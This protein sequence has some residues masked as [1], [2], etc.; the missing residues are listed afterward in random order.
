MIEDRSGQN[1]VTSAV[2]WI[3]ASLTGELASAIAIIAVAS[4]GLML[5]S[6]RLDMRRAVHVI[7]GCFILFGASTIATGIMQMLN[8]AAVA[9]AQP[10]PPPVLAPPA[11]AARSPQNYDPYAGAAVPTGR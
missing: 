1:A 2:R 6:G 7:F 3:Q 11:P 5:L 10:L 8:G 9:S 4:V